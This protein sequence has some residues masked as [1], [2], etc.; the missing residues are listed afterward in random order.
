M[1]YSMYVDRG[2]VLRMPDLSTVEG[3]ALSNVEGANLAPSS[4]LDIQDGLIEEVCCPS[5]SFPRFR[6]LNIPDGLMEGDGC[7]IRPSPK[8]LIARRRDLVFKLKGTPCPR[9]SPQK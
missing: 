3:P 2:A 5:Q 7:A 4:A 6:R 9:E 8:G 1:E